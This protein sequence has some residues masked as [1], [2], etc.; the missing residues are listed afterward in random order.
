MNLIKEIKWKLFMLRIKCL[1]IKIETLNKYM[2]KNYC[3]YGIHKIQSSGISYGGTNQRMK[4]ISFLRCHYCNY[5]FFAK[6]SDRERYLKHEQMTKGNAS[7][8][9]EN[10]S[11]GK[12]EHLNPSVDSKNRDV[13]VSKGVK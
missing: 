12:S 5:L 7:A 10:L 9:F 11:S 2:R 3:R 8:L 4:H 6:K 1:T 13:P